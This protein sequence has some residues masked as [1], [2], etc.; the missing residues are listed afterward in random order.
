MFSGK[1]LP[2]GLDENYGE[3][4]ATVVNKIGFGNRIREESFLNVCLVDMIVL[5]L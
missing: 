4:I 2:P 3:N 1:L 5:C